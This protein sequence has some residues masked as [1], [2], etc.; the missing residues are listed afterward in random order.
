MSTSSEREEAPPTQTGRSRSRRQPPDAESQTITPED[1]G[2]ISVDP[3]TETATVATSPH[4]CVFCQ[5]ESQVNLYDLAG[6]RFLGEPTLNI[7]HFICAGCN[8]A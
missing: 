8:D 1:V 6:G 3:P 5:E 7:R 2:V 4:T